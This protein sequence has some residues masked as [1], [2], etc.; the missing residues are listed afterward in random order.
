MRV[1]GIGRTLSAGIIFGFGLGVLGGVVSV[2]ANHLIDYRLFRLAAFTFRKSLSHNVLFFLILFAGLSGL[3]FLLVDRWKLDG[4][5][6]LRVLTMTMLVL[7]AAILVHWLVLPFPLWLITIRKIAG[8]PGRLMDRKITLDYVIF[9]VRSRLPG[10]IAL[11]V[12]IFVMWLLWRGLGR[13]DWKRILRLS[14]GKAVRR[15][16]IAML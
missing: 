15:T 3:W 11:G 8:V 6:V 5:R 2:L 1:T 7:I 10:G 12:G 14:E 16:A 13:L 9:L 4:F